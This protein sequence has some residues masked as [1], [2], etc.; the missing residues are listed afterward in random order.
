[1]FSKVGDTAL[2][3]LVP[4][5]E[6]VVKRWRIEHDPSAGEGMPAHVTVLY[7]FVSENQITSE[8]ADRLSRI[9]SET[10]P[11]TMRFV[12][13]G[14]FPRVLWLDPASAE[15]LH[16]IKLVHQQWPD[17][18]PYGRDD[19]DVVPHLTVTDGA[20]GIIM[21]GA[22]VDV[23]AGLPFESAVSHLSLMAFNGTSWICRR[24]FPFGLSRIPSR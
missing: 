22:E 18:L 16:L 6:R 19:F 23:M 24:Q 11:W 7:P 20:D 2:V 13:C 10:E 4:E 14:R 21:D 3:L 9:C 15:C 8:I 5:A 12:R 1:M 17:C